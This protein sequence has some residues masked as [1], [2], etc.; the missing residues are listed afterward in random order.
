MTKIN[1]IDFINQ[2]GGEGEVGGRRVIKN[3]TFLGRNH[4]NF[5]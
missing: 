4:A 5:C 2:Y 1:M 3:L